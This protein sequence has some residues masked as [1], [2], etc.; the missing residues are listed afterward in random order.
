MTSGAVERNSGSHWLPPWTRLEHDARYEFAAGFVSGKRVVDCACGTGIGSVLFASKGALEVRAIDSSAE[1]IAEAEKANTRS[2]LRITLGDA[3]RTGLPDGYADIFISLE[4][5]EH[6]E[7][8]AAFVE[9]AFRVVKPGGILICSTPNREITNP[10][11]SIT[12]APW[13]PFHVREYNLNEFRTLLESRFEIQ[14]VYG[15]NP[16]TPFRVR[17]MKALAKGIGTVVAVKINKLLKCRWFLISSP[18]HHAVRPVL[19]R[20]E[21]EFY[22]LV[23]R[24]PDQIN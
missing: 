5:I 3:T 2:S 11:T 1:A 21:Y 24:R 23:C 17:T 8:D 19:S 14:G 4:T 15:Q 20:E 18:G 16:V 9:E 10:G 6:L 13:N 7:D 22:V 12:D